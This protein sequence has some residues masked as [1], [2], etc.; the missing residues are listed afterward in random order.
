M[1]YQ[2]AFKWTLLRRMVLIIL[3]ARFATASRFEST[4][5]LEY[6]KTWSRIR[7]AYNP[8]LR[9]NFTGNVTSVVMSL[10]I[11]QFDSLNDD[12]KSFKTDMYLRQ[13]WVDYRATHNLSTVLIP[14][15]GKKHPSSY[16]WVPDTVF[17]G[18]LGGHVHTM[19]VANHKLDIYPN[20]TI[21]WGCRITLK[22]YCLFNLRNYPMDT[23]RCEVGIESYA[24][25][26]RHIN[27]I[28]DKTHP[29][30]LHL[31]EL[32]QHTVQVENTSRYLKYYSSS[33][34]KEGEYTF[35]KFDAVFKRR[36][37]AYILQA[38]FPS[39]SLVVVSWISFWFHTNCAVA[40]MSFG[41]VSLLTTYRLWEVVLKSMPKINYTTALDIY[42][43]GCI[44]FICFSLLEYGLATNFHFARWKKKR[45]THLLN[46]LNKRR[47]TLNQV[48]LRVSFSNNSKN[49][50]PL[51]YLESSDSK[52]THPEGVDLY[53]NLGKATIRKMSKQEQKLKLK[54]E[55]LNMWKSDPPKKRPYYFEPMMVTGKPASL[56]IA[57]RFLFPFGFLCFNVVY[58]A[59]FLQKA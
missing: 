25:D 15:I 24:Y 23:Q 21:Y 13:L 57:S 40:R 51:F 10:T 34:N 27:Y 33:S 6:S 44:T 20:G 9:P 50:R 7:Q 3:F 31:L 35:L 54:E 16:I 2:R 42:M 19:T 47:E 11:L 41:I 39:A 58:W 43:F 30:I 18:M 1:D 49:K 17:G 53:N 14:V 45:S 59:Y 55:Y 22:S 46:S 26:N 4:S 56:D 12:E 37:Q 52:A 5:D 29:V 28:W 38:Y 8:F 32:P 36:V 48:D